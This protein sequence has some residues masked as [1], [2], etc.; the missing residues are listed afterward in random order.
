MARLRSNG[1]ERSDS[2]T[3]G[4]LWLTNERDE[5][6]NRVVH[7]D[8]FA[9]A[10]RNW[11]WVRRQVARLLRDEPQAGVICEDVAINVSKKLRENP[12]VGSDLKAYFRASIRNRLRTEVA[13]AKK[14]VYLGGTQDLEVK[15]RQSAPDWTAA[16]DDRQTLAALAQHM[17][18]EVRVILHHLQARYTWQEIATRIGLTRRQAQSRFYYGV[19]RAYERL[20]EEQA[21]R[22]R[23]E[24]GESHGTE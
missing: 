8:V 2:P 14:I 20:L 18:H 10:R 4:K 13:R 5:Q 3:T 16:F 9:V 15:C 24:G 19:K 21:K 1:P 17:T 23:A 6:G 7:P 22:A 12:A 11:N